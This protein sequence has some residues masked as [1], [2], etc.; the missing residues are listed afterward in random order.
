MGRK[1]ISLE[2]QKYGRLIAVERVGKNRHGQMLWMCICDCGSEV[3]VRSGDLRSRNTK[4][5]GCLHNEELGNRRRLPVN[6]NFFSVWSEEM[7]YVMGFWAAD[8]CVSCG[9]RI[10]FCEQGRETI[11]KIK[12]L[13][14]SEHK[15]SKTGNCWVLS[16]TSQRQHKDLRKWHNQDLYKKSKKIVFPEIPDIYTRH[17]IRGYVDGDGSVLIGS[18]TVNPVV[19]VTSGSLMFLNGLNETISTHT[20]I[21]GNVRTRKNGVSVYYVGSIKAVCLCDWL[22]NK[23]KIAMP[24]K[25]SAARVVINWRGSKIMKASVTNKMRER[26]KEILYES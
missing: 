9:H 20:G 5:C 2:G 3:V 7:A 17:Y 14:K 26:F 6:H 21:V 12:D 4:S 18:D 19:K 13:V 22:Y 25:E 15:L 23:Q 10:S 11:Q 16:Y 24:R 8:G 1:A